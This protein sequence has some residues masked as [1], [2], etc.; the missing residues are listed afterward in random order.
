MRFTRHATAWLGALFGAGCSLLVEFPECAESRD[1]MPGWD[2]VAAVCVESGELEVVEVAEAIRADAEWTADRVYRL[3]GEIF[4]EPGKTLTIRAGTTIQGDEGSALIV[5][6]GARLEARGNVH[7]PIVFTSSRP[8]GERLPGDW[9]GVTLMGSAAVNEPGAVLEGV[10]DAAAAVYGGD[11]D[12]SSCGVLEY[13]RIEFAGFAVLKDAELNGLTLAGC[14][15]G[16]VV[17]HV[18]VHLAKD[19]GLEIF[20]GAVGLRHVLITRPQDDGLDWDRGWH[21]TGQ[22]VAIVQ[23]ELGD[24]GIEADNWTDMPDAEPRSRPVIYNLTAVSS[25]AGSQRGVTFKEGTGGAINNAVF[26][27]HSLEAIDVRGAETV[28]QMMQR[29]LTVEHA[30]F[31]KIGAGGSHFFPTPEDEQTMTPEDGRDDDASFDEDAFLRDPSHGHRF[32]VDPQLVDPFN[33]EAPD[34][35]PG[36]I[37]RE[38]VLMPPPEF[39]EGALYAGAFAPDGEPWTAGWTAFPEG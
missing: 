11:D 18:Q 31:F 34:L 5:R 15:A 23:D 16:T 4:V 32:G 30:L 14:G 36:P 25:G 2:C 33:R 21:G 7:A 20:G 6:R 12:G 35:R 10:G 28:A 24:N 17:D 19:D 9:G 38:G 29:R 22:F 26:V 39:D 27:G 8:A 37:A 3:K 1:C 13:V